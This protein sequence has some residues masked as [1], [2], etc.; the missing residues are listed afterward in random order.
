LGSGSDRRPGPKIAIVRLTSLG[1]V[2]HTLPLA[3]ALKRELPDSWILW[4][5]EE[6]ERVL[7]EQNPAVD[8]VIVGPSRRWRREAWNPLN[9]PRILREMA[10][11]RRQLRALRL[12]L[13]IDVQ[14]LPKSSLFTCLTGSGVR[15]GFGFRSVRDPF[16][17]FFTNRHVTPP[18]SAAHIVD[19][20]MALL[21][22]LGIAPSPVSF[23]LPTFGEASRR[24]D[25]FLRDGGLQPKDRL[26][27]LLPG[28]RGRAKQWPAEG[29]L[30]VAQRLALVGGVRLAL[31]GSPAE[32]DLLQGIAAPLERAAPLLFTGPI[33]E[34]VELLRRARLVI[35][36]DT[37]PLH[38]A[39]ALGRPTI[40]LFGP[41]RAERT[42]PYGPEARSLQSRTKRMRDLPAQAVVS[43]AL[44]SLEAPGGVDGLG[45]PPVATR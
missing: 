28:T 13:A 43:A 4:I 8:Q 12:D 34:L 17:A 3:A 18:T 36:N 23:P 7:V 29:Y 33:D 11:L 32:R 20:N 27:V 42:G 1:D 15:I 38:I 19:Q 22:P 41:T 21:G 39:A 9:H 26:V 5:V 45:M 40:G 14:G 35:G 10:A 31:V 25:D 24:I 30:E 6:H 2:V 44:S 16:A 37:G